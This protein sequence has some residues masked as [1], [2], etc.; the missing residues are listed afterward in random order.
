KVDGHYDTMS[1]SAREFVRIQG[2]DRFRIVD[3]DEPQ[4]FE[5]F[6]SHRFV[7]FDDCPEPLRW[8]GGNERLRK[9]VGSLRGIALRVIERLSGREDAR[10]FSRFAKLSDPH[11]LGDLIE[12]T[13]RGIQGVQGLLKHHADACPSDAWQLP[14]L[15]FER[16]D[17]AEQNLPRPDFRGG[18]REQAWDRMCE[19]ALPRASFA[20]NPEDAARFD[21]ERYFAQGVERP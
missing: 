16:V 15:K 17:S 19:R 10:H 20:D 6:P 11:G 2:Q 1:E 21:F 3:A 4:I 7:R 8:Q 18:L 9:H 13:V 14:L 12:N 5:D